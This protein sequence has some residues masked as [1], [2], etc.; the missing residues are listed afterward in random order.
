MP[1]PLLLHPIPL[2]PPFLLIVFYP[3]DTSVSAN[4][5]STTTTA[6]VSVGAA[7]LLPLFLPTLLLSQF[8]L[9]PPLRLFLLPS[10]VI[11]VSTTVTTNV[12]DASH[13]CLYSITPAKPLPLFPKRLYLLR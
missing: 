12:S 13:H 4:V 7:R 5:P 8:L 6:P 9:P 3:A 11:S 1:P 10:P 2:P